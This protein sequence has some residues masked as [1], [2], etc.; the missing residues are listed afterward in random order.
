MKIN[1]NNEGSRKNLFDSKSHSKSSENIFISNINLNSDRRS[2]RQR[3]LSG[4][5]YNKKWNL[6]KVISFD[7]IS[8]RNKENKNPIK[9]HYCERIFEYSPNYNVI[10]SN[11]QK[12]YINLGNSNDNINKIKNYKS[13]V[14]RKYLCNHLNIINNSG[15][16][17]N[18]LNVIKK[19]EEKQKK[20]K[21][22]NMEK[23]LNTLE[24][25]NYLINKKKMIQ[26]E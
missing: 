25:I 15:D 20:K 9:H 13:N 26:I 8:G 11:E 24:E 6:P 10:L 17:Y 22:Q 12:A 23:K 4:K 19:E 16:Y 5:I 18:I 2:G 7:K 14:T 3:K 21:V 1:Q